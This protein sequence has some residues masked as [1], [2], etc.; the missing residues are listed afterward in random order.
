MHNSFS[1]SND[2]CA[3]PNG[4]WVPRIGVPNVRP[5]V[6]LRPSAL[7]SAT[8]NFDITSLAKDKSN[9]RINLDE[10]TID[11]NIRGGI[12][13]LHTITNP[14]VEFDPVEKGDALYEMYD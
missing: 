4:T 11:Q 6:V 3:I 10:M 1:S 2:K 12:V 5:L 13:K 14:P 7:L 8:L 9:A